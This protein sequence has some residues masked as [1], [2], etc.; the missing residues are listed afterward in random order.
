MIRVQTGR[1]PLHVAAERGNADLLR[2]FAHIAETVNIGDKQ[3]QTPLHACMSNIGDRGRRELPEEKLQCMAVLI[4]YSAIL[5][6]CDHAGF[7][8]LHYACD[9]GNIQAVKLLL[10]KGCSIHQQGPV[11]S[12]A[13]ALLR[14]VSMLPPC[15]EEA[16][17]WT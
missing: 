2:Q 16:P 13:T 8:A 9:N 5:D 7:T 14:D 1:T 17:S 4:E 10:K 3:G 12:S 6:A 15:A 11:R